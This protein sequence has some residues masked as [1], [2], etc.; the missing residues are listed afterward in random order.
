MR[1]FW[2]YSVNLGVLI[3]EYI[4]TSTPMYWTTTA[5][6][7]PFLVKVLFFIFSIIYSLNLRISA[8]LNPNLKLKFYQR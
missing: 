6:C 4:H 7:E 5:N 8:S 3:G 2:M 1:D